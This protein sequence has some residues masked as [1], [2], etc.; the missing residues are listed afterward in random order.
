MSGWREHFDRLADTTEKTAQR[1]SYFSSA[2][3]EK[4]HGL[5][6]AA[7]NDMS[8]ALLL[9]A[10]CAD[11]TVTEPATADNTVIGFDFSA[12]ML[13]IATGRGLSCVQGD[14]LLPPFAPKSFDAVVCIEVVTITNAP[15]DAIEGLADLVR[16]GGRLVLS[17]LNAASLVRKVA[18]ALVR[19][20]VPA[21]PT[22]LD[23]AMVLERISNSGLAVEDERLTF[24][25]PCISFDL[26]ASAHTEL[27][28]LAANNL[29]IVARRPA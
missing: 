28:L 11:G 12:N 25:L 18:A 22:P 23:R 29:F 6:R 9:D 19:P 20:F 15:Y 5:A 17:V 3:T 4:L 14:V 7:V 10:G 26:D 24:P 16:P 1:S 2:N 8:G 13:R 27:K 21:L